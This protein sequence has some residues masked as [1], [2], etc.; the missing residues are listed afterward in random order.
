MAPDE[1][2]VSYR[3]PDGTYYMG[4]SEVPKVGDTL[5]SNSHEWVVV[6]VARGN[7]GRSITVTLRPANE[8]AEAVEAKPD[9]AGGLIPSP[10]A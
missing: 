9:G 8:P 2:V 4:A 7:K 6:R 1:Q 5:K 3:F 10:E